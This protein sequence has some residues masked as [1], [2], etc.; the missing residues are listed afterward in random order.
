[1][2]SHIEFSSSQDRVRGVGHMRPNEVLHGL[3]NGG[4]KI[5]PH[6]V[7]GPKIGPRLCA[8]HVFHVFALNFSGDVRSREGRQ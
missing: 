1:M 3:L 6:R 4:P 7:L 8:F 2:R 5:D